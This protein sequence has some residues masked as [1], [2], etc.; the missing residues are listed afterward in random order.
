MITVR[1]CLDGT[2]F[3]GNWFIAAV[4]SS[5]ICQD[6]LE[7]F[8]GLIRRVF[9]VLQL[10]RNV[11][12]RTIGHIRPAKIQIVSFMRTSKT[13]QTAQIWSLR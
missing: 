10:N 3:S 12:K 13:D 5:Q 1:L 7:I 9:P 2:F 11:K 4:T 8:F 6:T